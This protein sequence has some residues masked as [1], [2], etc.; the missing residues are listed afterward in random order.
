MIGVVE[1]LW[2]YPVKSM[3]GESLDRLVVDG[4]GAVGDR[5]FAV[6]D[7]AGKFGSGK[8]TRRFRRIDGLFRFHARC[9]GEAPV[10]GFPDGSEIAG[11]DPLVHEAL[12]RALGL[13]VTLAREAAVSH[14]DAGPLHLIT[15]SSL[16]AIGLVDH[17]ALRFRPNLLIR[18]DGTGFVEDEWLGRR[19]QLG[20]EVVVEVV[21][22]TERCRMIGLQQGELP[23]SP[24]LLRQLAETR[25]ARFGV[26]A[27]VLIPGAIHSGDRLRFAV[28]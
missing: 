4:R 10:V 23:D 7:E 25:H 17:D 9:E 14:L 20:H 11:D 3:R 22:T 8:D 24:G 13:Q 15:T 19:I 5:L 28:P 26:Y 1:R 18:T 12:S 27:Q 2:R 6:R 21:S 16:A